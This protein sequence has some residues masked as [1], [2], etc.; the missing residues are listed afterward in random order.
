MS[1][2]FKFTKPTAYMIVFILIRYVD[3]QSNANIFILE[4]GN[5][6]ATSV[7]R[8]GIKKATSDISCASLCSSHGT[9]CSATYEIEKNTC[10]LDSCCNPVTEA[11][12]G[13]LVIRTNSKKGKN[14]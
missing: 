1:F 10:F 12:L 2:Q 9:C 11:F 8:I 7:T 14:R 3:L 13:A 6:I 4:T 5:R